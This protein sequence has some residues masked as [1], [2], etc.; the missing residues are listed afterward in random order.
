MLLE[1]AGKQSSSK[2]TKHIR[3]RYFFIKDRVSN[4][5]ITLKHCLTGEML[6]DHF[7]KPLQGGTISKI[8]SVNTRYSPQHQISRVGLESG[9][10]L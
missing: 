2:R 9:R 7:T 1:T 10:T 5:N 8:Q 4:G 6:A 3:V